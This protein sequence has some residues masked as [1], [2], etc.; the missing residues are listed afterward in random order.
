M[1]ES[2]QVTPSDQSAELSEMLCVQTRSVITWALLA[3]NT[4]TSNH[5]GEVSQQCLS[6]CQ[7]VCQQHLLL[8]CMNITEAYW[9]TR[10]IKILISN[11]FLKRKI[12]RR[13]IFVAFCDAKLVIVF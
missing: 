3:A 2:C 5:F 1:V 8:G 10:N 4:Y 13:S 9:H 6:V 11:L 12:Y 7:S